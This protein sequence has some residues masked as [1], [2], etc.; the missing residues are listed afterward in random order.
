[1]INELV[2]I[3]DAPAVAVADK[4]TSIKISAVNTIPLG[5]KTLVKIIT[6]HGII[7]WGEIPQ[8]P[9]AVACALVES[10]FDE[11]FYA[12]TP[13]E[14]KIEQIFDDSKNFDE[15]SHAEQYDLIFVDGSHAQSYVESDSQ[16]ALRMLKPGGVILWHDYRG[17]LRTQGVYST[18]NALSEKYP[19]VH[20]KG[21][22]IVAYRRVA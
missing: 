11:F 16:K 19:L 6:N 17:P 2:N 22:C 21:T 18:L 13:E 12:G 15:S 8:V 10:M 20:I 3:A 14:A 9:P 1:M 5:G 7:G 4:F